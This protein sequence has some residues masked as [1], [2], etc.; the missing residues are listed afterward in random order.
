VRRFIFLLIPSL[1][2]LSQAIAQSP[3]GT[4]NGIVLDPSGAAIP[5]A[6]IVVI[7]DGTG[8]QYTTRA[9]GMGIYVVSNLP[10]GPYRIQVSNSGF[11]TII[12]P[13][14]V[15]HVQDAL[16]IN[17]TLPIG[18]ASEIV[19]VEGGAPLV[20]TESA[21]VSTVVDRQFVENTPLN[22]RSFQTLIMLAPG[23]VLTPANAANQ[24]Q[25]SVDGQRSDA[26]YFSVDGVS[27]NIST[28]VGGNL[29]QAGGGSLPGFS[30]LGGTNGLVSVDA[31][32]E[33]R[34][35][36][37]SF[38]PEFGRTPGGQISIVTR[39]G[40]NDFHGTLFEYFRNDVLDA[41]DWFSDEKGLRKAPD[42]QNDF[43]GVLGG[44]IIK[45]K[46]FFF[47]SYEGLRL[48]QPQTGVSVVPDTATRQTAS[49]SV[50]PYLN[51]F[52]VQN[53]PE[54]GNGL[55]QFN[56]SYSNPSTLDSYS[57]RVDH[58]IG[59]RFTLFGRYNY[60]PSETGSRIS[61]LLSL[62]T[63]QPFSTQTFTLGLTGIVSKRISNE[64]RANYSNFR[65]GS[66]FN[67]TSFGGAVPLQDS[68]LF[69]PGFSS[70]DGISGISIP[71]IGT[72]LQGKSAID[73]QRQINL[74][75]NLS[76]TAGTHQLK[77]GADYRWLA[78][79]ASP[80]S[81][82]QLS[83]FGGLTGPSGLTSGVASV[84]VL[85]A[86]QPNALLSKNFSLYSQDTWKA[87]ERLTLTYG[88]RWDVNPPIEGKNQQSEPFT[89]TNINDPAA[90]TLAPRGTPLYSTTYGNVAPRAGIAYRLR[91][92]GNWESVLR[93]GIGVFYDLG[94]GNLGNVTTG[95]PYTALK[96]LFA[97]PFPVPPSLA[98]P[99]LFNLNLP[100]NQ[101]FY[102]A[103]PNLKLPRTY[104][105]NTAVE[106]T[107]G[108]MQTVSLTYVGAIGRDLL[109]QYFLGQPNPDFSSVFVTGNTGNSDYQA[110]QFKF[111]RR[112]NKGLQA[113]ASYTFSHSIDNASDDSGL[114]TPPSLANSE[115]DRGD[116]DFDVRHSFTA[117][118]TYNAP[119]PRRQKLAGVFL[120]N[121]SM[122]AFVFARSALPVNI[123]G[124]SAV[125]AGIESQVRPNVVT[126][127]PFYLYGPQFPGG[128]SFN[129]TPNQGGPGCFGPFCP[130]ATGQ[131]GDLGRNVL[132]G[133]GAWQTD[134]A[135]RRQF[136]LSEKLGLQCRAE[137]FNIL[138]HPN[139]GDPIMTNA[140]ISSPLFGRSTLTL[141]NRLGTGG[142]GGGFNPL[143]QI[144]GPRSI[145]LAMKLQF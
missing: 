130:P 38:A 20:N 3:N 2:C 105:W 127:I 69:P 67:L 124:A 12:K 142:A 4:I 13:D 46:T 25:F 125:V 9:N 137:F 141:A 113:L 29:G 106:Q 107:L 129:N 78:P 119:F 5:G 112:M 126:G 44:P 114:F 111:Q 90:M 104:E 59:S 49:A 103:L 123:Y 1:L 63:A 145:Q 21:A 110:L 24:G 117:A 144:G 76:V 115:V 31:M 84:V 101:N 72:M 80:I 128:K 75:D 102:V 73:E 140:L 55:A 94:V 85:A 131:Q 32:Q 87:S 52:P 47:F 135:L 98:A 15:I 39:A 118:L 54:L 108:S 77:F 121:W 97:A 45:R 81:Y 62:T 43:G 143:Y 51:A 100:A 82:E 28:G 138:N 122:D 66:S 120:R 86:D 56:A 18:A 74:V 7:N 10:P 64:L 34:I 27:A 26:N 60:S 88:L 22:G 19:T 37:S 42:R 17:F 57:L 83:I 134:F 11:K 30:A 6:E 16:A 65:T 133:F 14:I 136:H 79:F 40:T 93:A 91:Q 50:Q 61:T 8:V 33:F 132:R 48:R 70:R 36:T 116:S 23:V 71:G 41:N 109:R 96:L 92:S 58:N 139:F 68:T 35:Q 95:F 53:G 99:P 89:L